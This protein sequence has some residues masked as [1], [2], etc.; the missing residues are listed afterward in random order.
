MNNNNIDELVYDNLNSLALMYLTNLK[1]F[2][3]N[4]LTYG[5]DTKNY[6]KLVINK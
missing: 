5:N 6:I 2:F 1:P 4:N 3:Y